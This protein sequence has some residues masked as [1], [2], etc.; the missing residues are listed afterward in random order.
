[1]V[2]SVRSTGKN[3]RIEAV[4]QGNEH[5]RTAVQV[6]VSVCVCVCVC[7]RDCVC[8]PLCAL[9]VVPHVDVYGCVRAQ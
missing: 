5:V 8:V 6:V 9:N 4:G 7:V 1:M 3:E 2:G